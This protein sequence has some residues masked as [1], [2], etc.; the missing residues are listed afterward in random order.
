VSILISLLVAVA[1]DAVL[2]EPRRF[3]PLVGFGYYANRLEYGFGRTRRSRLRGAFAWALAVMPWVCITA[4]VVGLSEGVLRALIEGAVLYL[5]IGWQS[6]IRHAKAIY[7]PLSKNDLSAARDAV[8]MIVSRDTHELDQNAVA[9][10][11]TESVLENGA[12][13]V[14]AALFWFVLA[15]APGVVCYRLANTL[16]AMWGYK[17]SRYIDFGW[18]A[19]RIDDVLNFVPARL[20]ALSYALSG[21]FAGGISAWRA[22]SGRWKSPNAGPVM[23]AGAGAIGVSL[24]GG[25]VYHGQW[26][27]RPVLGL[28]TDP[29]ATAQ[30]ILRA[31]TLV[32]R[33]LVLWLFMLAL[34]AISLG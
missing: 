15:G 17:S 4:L 32:N 30:S 25:A 1:L 34:V 20:T 10:A 28:K 29:Q 9:T 31:I 5:A 13:A 3:H 16:D 7:E 14:F 24:G 19:A 18:A 33:S 26:Q 12:D 6:L 11:A 27:E 2:S 23:A 8:G 21:R 22:Q